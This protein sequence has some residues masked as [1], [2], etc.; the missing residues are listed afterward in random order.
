MCAGTPLTPFSKG[1][2]RSFELVCP[3]AIPAR[4]GLVHCRAADMAVDPSEY[5]CFG[6]YEEC[7]IYRSEES[8][9]CETCPLYGSC[10]KAQ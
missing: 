10:P 6:N 5:P 2:P 7:P 8:G 1:L 4:G 3:Y 9:S